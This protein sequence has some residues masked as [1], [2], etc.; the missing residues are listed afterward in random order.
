MLTLDPG[1]CTFGALLAALPLTG[2][3][4]GVVAGDTGKFVFPPEDLVELASGKRVRGHVVWEDGSEV[5]V[6]K[7]TRET[8]YPIGDVELVDSAAR[9]SRAF[10][11]IL[12]GAPPDNVK[13][14]KAAAIQAREDGLVGEERIA[15]TYV[16]MLVPADEDAH[17]GLG[18]K[19]K[20]GQWLWRD[21]KRFRTLDRFER[22]HSDWGDAWEFDT[23]H[24]HIRSNLPLATTVRAALDLE[25]F[26][27]AVTD[28]FPELQLHEPSTRFEANLHADSA[29]FPE[30]DTNRKAYY[31]AGDQRLVVNMSG[32]PESWSLFHEATH[33]ILHAPS[34]E[35]RGTIPDWISEGLAEYIAAGAD[36]SPGNAEF[37]FGKLALHH[38]ELHARANSPYDLRRVLTLSAG[39]FMSS[40][41]A[42]LKYAQAYTLVTFCLDG[43]D[44]VH[45]KLFLEYLRASWQGKGSRKEF[46]QALGIDEDE[47]EEGWIQFVNDEFQ[48][49]EHKRR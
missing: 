17:L 20:Q 10:L 8:S 43:V 31:S 25:R 1:L 2:V 39:D 41:S 36:G 48:N 14:L 30:T 21:G 13:A 42:A 7:G 16:L 45:R 44:A 3:A 28:S 4:G 11:G 24:Y 18:N 12:D 6:R 15:W 46:Y 19:Y 37:E 38:L 34:V 23:I 33:Q 47:F 9:K 26:Y 40:S 35:G 29:S 27:R 22:G 5:V 32:G 49:R